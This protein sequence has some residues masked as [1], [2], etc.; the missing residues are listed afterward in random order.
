MAKI[1]SYGEASN[2]QLTDR[3]IG[4]EV[5]ADPKNDTKNFTIDQLL[6]LLG[7]GN[8]GAVLN[9][10]S[11]NNDTEAGA[12]GLVT[13]QLWVFTTGLGRFVMVKQ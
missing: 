13:G 11:F 6:N 7:G 5:N 3:L 1:S 9:L 2:P 12:A 8:K 10:P 4:T